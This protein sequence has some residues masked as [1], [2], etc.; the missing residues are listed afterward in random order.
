MRSL[1]SALFVPL[2]LAATLPMPRSAA[3][4]TATAEWGLD[5]TS[6]NGYGAFGGCYSPNPS[7]W[8]GQT[9]TA[10]TA[11]RL[12]SA[13]IRVFRSPSY[14]IGLRVE[15]YAVDGSGYPAGDPLYAEEDPTPNLHSGQ[16]AEVY[17]MTF[18]GDTPILQAGHDYALVFTA[19]AGT[20]QNGNRYTLNGRFDTG[21]TY[22]G[23][24]GIVRACDGGVWTVQ[25]TSADWG[26]RVTVD[27][28]VGVESSSWGTLKTRF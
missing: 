24:Q 8:R 15:I 26:F 14:D 9:F 21:A 1:I 10:D 2:V 12:I 13:S 20:A 18:S 5:D 19:P 6:L 7:A 3:A 16:P 23:G 22:A 11:G 17:T 28:T 25:S 4:L 27:E